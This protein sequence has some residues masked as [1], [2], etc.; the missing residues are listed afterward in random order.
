MAQ[1]RTV[2]QHRCKT[3]GSKDTRRVSWVTRTRTCKGTV[4]TGTGTGLKVV[5]P[6]VTRVTP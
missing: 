1:T 4:L 6:R 3:E 2:L 5:H